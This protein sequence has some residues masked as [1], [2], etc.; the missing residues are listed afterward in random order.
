LFLLAYSRLPFGSIEFIC[1]DLD[2]DLDLDL[3]LN[4]NLNLAATSLVIENL[5]IGVVQTSAR[6]DPSGPAS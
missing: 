4:L 6:R 3:N 1:L 2:L 5:S